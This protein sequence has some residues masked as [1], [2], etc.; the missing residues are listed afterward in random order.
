MF[1][2][3]K[4]VRSLVNYAIFRE[5]CDQM[6]SEVDCGKS[7]HRIIS[8]GLY[9]CV[10][11]WI[12]G[13]YVFLISSRFFSSILNILSAMCCA[14]LKPETLCALGYLDLCLWQLSFI[15]GVDFRVYTVGRN[16]I[17]HFRKRKSIIQTARSVKLHFYWHL[18]YTPVWAISWQLNNNFFKEVS[19]LFPV[20]YI[21]RVNYS[22]PPRTPK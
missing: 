3:M 7:H 8:E 12:R 18:E 6:R 19:K 9:S 11:V 21:H 14:T 15:R 4:I 2:F 10:A 17:I 22:L 1:Y 5:L 16:G 13:L 20:F